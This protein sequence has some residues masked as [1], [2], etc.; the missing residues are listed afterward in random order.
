[1]TNTNTHW[2]AICGALLGA[3]GG[4][5]DGAPGAGPLTPA[6]AQ[7][8]CELG[9]ARD[10]MCG[11]GAD[12]TCVADCVAGAGDGNFRGDVFTAAAECAADLPC[13]ADE[14]ACLTCAPTADHERYETA[15]RAKYTECGLDAPTID[16]NCEVTFDGVADTGLSCL[17]SPGLLDRLTAC[18]AM[19]CDLAAPC[20]EAIYAEVFGDGGN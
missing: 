10:E 1:M 2:L 11:A 9:C 3:C 8:V 19:T 7:E 15:C 5:G 17:F 20:L 14:D 16:A 18:F 13:E 12:P 6:Q 4:D